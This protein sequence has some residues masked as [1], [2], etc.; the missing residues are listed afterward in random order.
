[1]SSRMLVV[2]SMFKYGIRSNACGFQ[3]ALF[4]Q[5]TAVAS[6]VPGF[7]LQITNQQGIKLD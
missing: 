7:P 2:E 3:V 5:G 1:M 6:P 4:H